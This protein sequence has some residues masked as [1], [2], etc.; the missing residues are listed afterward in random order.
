MAKL[1]GDV[2]AQVC[3]DP[4][5]EFV[6]EGATAAEIAAQIEQAEHE[7][8]VRCAQKAKEHNNTGIIPVEY[9]CVVRVVEVEQITAGG[10]IKPDIRRDRDQMAMTT[11]TL[12]EAGG[13]AFTEPQWRGRTPEPGDRVL[14]QKYAGQF[15]EAD[16]TDP[17][18]VVHDKE[19]LAILEPS[20]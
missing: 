8:Q 17:V 2:V 4:N 14:I 9:K 13:N 1:K 18:R 6:I 16:P 5:M 7:R 11:A 10:I 19:I 20:A 12:L 3:D 15:K